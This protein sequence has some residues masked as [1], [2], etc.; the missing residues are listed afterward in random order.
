ML[1]EPDKTDLAGPAAGGMLLAGRYRLD[2]RLTR[3]GGSSIWKAADEA[4]A[5]PVTVH[6]FTAGFRRAGQVVAA[7]RAAARLTDA[8]LVRIFDADDRPGHSCMVVTEWPHG[9]RLDDLLAA[10]PLGPRRAGE[11]IAEAADVLAVAHAAGLAHLCLTPGSLWWD[12]CGDV[13]ISGLATAAALT[14]VTAADP[15]AADT[16]GLASLLYAALTGC[17]PGTGQTSLA[18]APRRAGRTC[19][20]GQVHGG[21]PRDIDAVTCR[22]LFGEAIGGWPPI[23]SP[24]QLCAELAAIGCAVRPPL[25]QAPGPVRAPGPVPARALLMTPAGPGPAR[26][27]PASPGPAG[28]AAASAAPASA[29]PASPVLAGPVLARPSAAPAGPALAGRGS[30]ST[31]PTSAGQARAGS[32]STE[33][34]RTGLADAGTVSAGSLSAWPLVPELAV[35][36]GP[37]TPVLPMPPILPIPTIPPVLSVSPGLPGSAGSPGSPGLPGPPVR[38]VRPVLAGSPGS[39]GPSAPAVAPASPRPRGAGP[40]PHPGAAPPRPPARPGHLA[41]VP[42]GRVRALLAVAVVIVLAAIV[43]GGWLLARSMT[44]PHGAAAGPAAVRELR[45]ASAAAF[46]PYG[47]GQGGSSQLGYRAIDASPAT[48]WHTEWYTTARFGNLKPGTGL[49]VDMGRK[50]TLAGARITLGAAAPGADFQLRVGNSAAALADLRP[51]ASAA[52][53]SDRVSLRLRTPA[54]GRYVLIW[55]TKLPPDSAGTYQAN[56]YD[57][58][59]SGRP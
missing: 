42:P 28:P 5:R 25:A 47:T 43:A 29:W 54:D 33:Q 17:W 50:V 14:G 53:A 46:D 19:S 21:I 57:I 38:P 16:R 6:I 52:S 51:V 3:E 4:L 30:T 48:Y 22:A 1:S 36:A 40:A 15:A 27:A 45:P 56:V 34:T 2:E 9:S 58:R 13:K 37:V 35:P 23:L 11:I 44:A 59:L 10:G 49:L 18:A 26:P 8:R 12:T 39:L 55:F 32:T 41:R 20:P 24:A 7:A 31:G